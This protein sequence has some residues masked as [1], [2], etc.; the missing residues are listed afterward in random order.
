MKYYTVSADP[1]FLYDGILGVKNNAVYPY[2]GLDTD[3]RATMAGSVLYMQRH[4]PVSNAKYVQPFI[5]SY[6]IVDVNGKTISFKT[7]AIVTKTGRSPGASMDYSF[8]ENIP[9]DAVTVTKD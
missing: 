7:Y 5:P 6:T 4:L 9:Y 1:Y 2:L 3:A 8:D